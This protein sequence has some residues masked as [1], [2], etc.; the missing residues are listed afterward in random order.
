MAVVVGKV[1]EKLVVE[2][3]AVVE[4]VADVVGDE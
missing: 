1:D 3:G 2:I 4:P